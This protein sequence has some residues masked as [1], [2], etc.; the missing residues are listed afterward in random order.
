MKPRQKVHTLLIISEIL[1]Y[2]SLLAL[3]I[4]G[5]IKNPKKKEKIWFCSKILTLKQIIIDNMN[6][7]LPFKEI[8]S[9]NYFV[10]LN[11]NYS[12]LLMHSTKN[13]CEINYQKCGILDSVKNIMCIPK[14]EICPLNDI[15]TSLNENSNDYNIVKY[16]NY[17]LYSTNHNINNNIITNITISY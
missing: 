10:Q 11:R 17:L 1:L 14:S 15:K 6:A 5:C 12:Y 16:Y 13:E 3:S 9:E 4:I 7:T 2:L 8:I